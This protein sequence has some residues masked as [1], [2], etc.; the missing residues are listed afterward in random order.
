MLATLWSLVGG[1]LPLAQIAGPVGAVNAMVGFASGLSNGLVLLWVVL[2]LAFFITNI[3]PI[4]AIDGGQILT[5]SLVAIFGE[6]WRKP[7]DKVTMIF[8]YVLVIFMAVVLTK[9]LW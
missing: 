5:S 6:K 4:P 7:L 8:F 2:N 3:L 1:K 9:D